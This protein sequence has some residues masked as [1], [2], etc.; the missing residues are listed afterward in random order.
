MLQTKE[1]NLRVDN[2]SDEIANRY[3]IKCA[4]S[5]IIIAAIIWVLN[6]INVFLVDKKMVAICFWASLF[7]YLA[8]GIVFRFVSLSNKWVKY[9]ALL[10]LEVIITIMTTTMTF[11][12][13]FACIVPIVCSSIYCSKR[14]TVYTYILTVISVIITV[15]VGYYYGLCD[16]NMT[17]LS[18]KPMAEYLGPNNEFL[19]TKVNTQPIYSLTLFFVVPRCMICSCIAI[20]SSNISKIIMM[21]VSYAEKMRNL[22][23]IDGMT[24]LYNKSRY[25]NMINGKYSNEKSV[26][27]IFWD[28]NALKRIN[29]TVGHEAGDRLISAVATSIKNITDYKGQAYRVGGDEFVM[30]V[31]DCDEDGVKYRISIWNEELDKVRKDFD[32]PISVSVGYAVG[33]GRNIIDIIHKADNMMY[34]NKREWHKQEDNK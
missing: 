6:V 22:A 23:E 1:K 18:G 30:I 31:S 28:V 29:D 20:L 4:T 21:N 27:V 26:A 10:W 24:G 14:I 8:G 5:A 9:Y 3:A 11:H 16:A 33:E 25:L 34:E 7:V 19:L 12:A 15:F 2:Y 13:V 17:L 32:I